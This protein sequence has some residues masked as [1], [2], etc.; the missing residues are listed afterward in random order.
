MPKV[1]EN[2]SAGRRQQE[3]WYRAGHD[4]I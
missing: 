4:V 1:G 3:G 2:T